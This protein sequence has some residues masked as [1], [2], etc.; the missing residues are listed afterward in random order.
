MVAAIDFNSFVPD[1][2]TSNMDGCS[3]EGV[4]PAMEEAFAA[5]I[6]S[7]VGA[8]ELKPDD[9]G[10]ASVG[11]LR[12]CSALISQSGGFLPPAETA[13]VFDG[14][15]GTYIT[16]PIPSCDGGQIVQ[17]KSDARI[18]T[19]SDLGGLNRS[20]VNAALRGVVDEFNGL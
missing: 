6:G 14:D 17:P 12:R 8:K 9:V 20:G 2:V 1:N 15:L 11:T 13:T 4:T 16:I 18:P 19:N 3:V 5:S 10:V 7:G